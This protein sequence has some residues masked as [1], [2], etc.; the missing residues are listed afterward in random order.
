[1]TDRYLQLEG[2]PEHL[3]NVY[4]LMGPDDEVLNA[5]LFYA[6]AERGLAEV[7]KE[8]EGSTDPGEIEYYDS[9]HIKYMPIV[10][11]VGEAKEVPDEWN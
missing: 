8:G 3:F 1:M 5:Y 4:H 10:G 11:W 6:D 7:R 2:E 9:L